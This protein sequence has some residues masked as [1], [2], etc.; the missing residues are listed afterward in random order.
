MDKQKFTC[1]ADLPDK[2]TNAGGT[3]PPDLLITSQKPDIVVIDR[4]RKSVNI[5]ELTV[6][7]EHNIAARNKDKSDRYASMKTD[8]SNYEVNIE[9]FEIGARAYI[10][11]DNK[12]RLKTIFKFCKKD[13]S[14]KQFEE[15]VA[16]LA[17]EGSKYIYLC[18]DQ[19]EWVTP[20]L[21][22]I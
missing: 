11:K 4:K 14:Y 5:F 3:L 7:F 19:T 1:Y 2:R 9:P 21:L 12:S 10:S 18:R 22:T 13:I 15:N 16:R 20:P 8:I 17:I 6:P